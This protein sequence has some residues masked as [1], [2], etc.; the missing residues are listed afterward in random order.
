[1]YVRVCVKRE[2]IGSA[3]LPV[4]RPTHSWRRR[5][6]CRACNFWLCKNFACSCSHPTHSL[7][8]KHFEEKTIK[9]II[10]Q[11]V[12]QTSASFSCVCHPIY[13]KKKKTPN[14]IFLLFSPA[15]FF[16]FSSLRPPSPV[17]DSP[18]VAII[19]PPAAAFFITG[20]GC[21]LL[22]NICLTM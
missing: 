4:C 1:M 21:D 17:P 18:Q 20:C 14:L 2:N 5:H 19:F 16:S 8:T 12:V 13:R 3:A 6:H 22:I 9:I 11:S 7:T 10:C 15:P